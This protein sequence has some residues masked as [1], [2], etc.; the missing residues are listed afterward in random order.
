M[1]TVDHTG[2]TVAESNLTITEGST[3]LLT[4]PEGTRIDLAE[5]VHKSVLNGLK[6]DSR[7]ITLAPGF[8]LQVIE[9][10]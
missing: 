9:I 10:E 3:F 6:N 7:V 4:P 5:A 2:N 8:K 1:K